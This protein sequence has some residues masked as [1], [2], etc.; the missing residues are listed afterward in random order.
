M[1]IND[2]K[3]RLTCHDHIIMRTSTS[4]LSSV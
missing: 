1:V 4:S 2:L 3:I